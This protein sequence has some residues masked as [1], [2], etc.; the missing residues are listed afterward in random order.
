[1]NLTTLMTR[2]LAGL[3]INVKEGWADQ[4]AE[5]AGGSG[6]FS[7]RCGMAWG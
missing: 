6:G 4:V 7:V 2:K 3:L 5:A 1:M